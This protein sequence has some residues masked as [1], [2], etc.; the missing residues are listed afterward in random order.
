MPSMLV[1]KLLNQILI[2]AL[3]FGLGINRNSQ[4]ANQLN[5]LTLGINYYL[6][7]SMQR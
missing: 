7:Y 3:A 4:V 5:N 2:N 1:I 6:S